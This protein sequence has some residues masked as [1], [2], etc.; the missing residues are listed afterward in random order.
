MPEHPTDDF[1]TEQE[2]CAASGMDRYALRR[3]RRWLFISPHRTFGRGKGSLSYYPRSLV[4]VIR[5]F[6]EVL[7][8]T[9]SADQSFWTIWLEDFPVD[10]VQWADTRLAEFEKLFRRLSADELDVAIDAIS[11]TTPT[12]TSVRSSISSRLRLKEEFSLLRWAAAVAAGV[13]PPKS[14]YDPVSPPFDALKQAAGLTGNWGAPDAELRIESFDLRRMR[15]VLREATPAEMEQLR[16]DCKVIAELAEASKAIDWLA[17]R[18]ALNVQRTSSAQP[19]PPVDFFLKQWRNFA[20]RAVII[21]VLIYIRRLP[22]YSHKLSE[23]L[24]AAGSVLQVLPRRRPKKG[25]R[26]EPAPNS[27]AT[28]VQ[29]QGFPDKGTGPR[30]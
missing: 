17:V 19:L 23:I 4:P 7:S 14:L 30:P 15:D 20:A 12:R 21:S 24:A 22:D 18:K 8:Q 1:L 3:I 5:R 10:M 13:A 6:Y 9:R 25:A 28:E 27:T 29:S 2:L 16:R 11:K 26:Q